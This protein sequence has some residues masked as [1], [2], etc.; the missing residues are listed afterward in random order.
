M[1]SGTRTSSLALDEL[2]VAVREGDVVV[3]NRVAR[4][5][6]N[7]VHTIQLAE[8]FNCHSVHFWAL[9]LGIDS[10]SQRAK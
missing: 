3:V 1:V 9:N 4:L 10:R 5:G 6:H 8:E 7:T 2:L